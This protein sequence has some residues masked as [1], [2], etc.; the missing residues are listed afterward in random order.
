M[1]QPPRLA[2][3]IIPAATGSAVTT[4]TMTLT[5]L[6]VEEVKL[7]FQAS[8]ITRVRNANHV[9]A[10]RSNPNSS[11]GTGFVYCVTIHS[12]TRLTKVIVRLHPFP[13]AHERGS[14]LR[15]HSIDEL[16]EAD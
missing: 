7:I 6:R 12:F 10:L 9:Y 11:E 15:A 3:A 2:T 8:H 5:A 4:T 13:Q 1:L 14:P 16:E